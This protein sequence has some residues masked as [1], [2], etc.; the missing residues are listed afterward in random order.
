MRSCKQWMQE[1]SYT[2]FTYCKDVQRMTISPASTMTLRISSTHCER[3]REAPF[4]IEKWR[5]PVGFAIVLLE[6]YHEVVHSP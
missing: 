6:E 1:F 2:A 3:Y 4:K 5:V